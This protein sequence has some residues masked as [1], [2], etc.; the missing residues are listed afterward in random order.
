MATTRLA[1]FGEVADALQVTGDANGRHDLTQIDGHRLA[2]GDDGYG[3]LLDPVLQEVDRRIAGDHLLG[4]TDVAGKQ[5]LGRV[6]ERR[7]G[8]VCH[9]AD[10]PIEDLELGVVG[11]DR[12]RLHAGSSLLHRRAYPNRPV[13]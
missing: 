5:R 12:M 13:M 6:L 8:A 4:E 2:R 7:L 3:L 1:T 10:Q 9:I 11:S